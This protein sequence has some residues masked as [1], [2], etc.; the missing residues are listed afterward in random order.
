M[1]GLI[2]TATQSAESLDSSQWMKDNP[3]VGIVLGILVSGL[4]HTGKMAARPVI[5]AGTVGAGLRWSR[6]SGR[7]LDRALAHRDLPADPGD[8]SPW[9]SWRGCSSGSGSRCD[10]GAATATAG[11]IPTTPEGAPPSGQGVRTSSTAS[12][13]Y[14]ARSARR[15]VSGRVREAAQ[16]DALEGCDDESVGPASAA[17]LARAGGN[18]RDDVDQT[19]RHSASA[20]PSSGWRNAS[21]RARPG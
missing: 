12:V 3:W 14:T 8:P 17:L 13:R 7:R 21:D 2:F 5:N 11:C 15:S 4:V 19:A 20:A 18:L 1:G 9:C 16:Q 10:V 6:R